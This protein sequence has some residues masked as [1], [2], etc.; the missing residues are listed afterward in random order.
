MTK[1]PGK[2]GACPPSCH[3]LLWAQSGTSY[4]VCTYLLRGCDPSCPYSIHRQAEVQRWHDSL[5]FHRGQPWARS[6]GA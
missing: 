6:C 4:L 5:E 3:L 1:G 2:R